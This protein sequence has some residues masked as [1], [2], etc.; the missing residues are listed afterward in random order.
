MIQTPPNSVKLATDHQPPVTF[1]VPAAAGEALNIYIYIYIYI[2]ARTHVSARNG[3]SFVWFFVF[4]SILKYHELIAIFAS[5]FQNHEF[6]L[7]FFVFLVC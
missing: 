2:F 5:R 3:L 7:S 4:P 1:W 6:G